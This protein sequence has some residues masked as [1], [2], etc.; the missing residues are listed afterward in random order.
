V[1]LDG[2]LRQEEPLADLP[3]HQSVGDELKDLELSSGRFLLELAKDGRRREGDHRA[4]ALRVP[5][6]RSRL[7]STAVVAVSVQDLS[8]LRG[9]H[10]M[11]IGTA[12]TAH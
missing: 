1:R 8:T 5:T 7:E 2:L 12:E 11:R 10:A 3:V 9:V 4:G 6:R